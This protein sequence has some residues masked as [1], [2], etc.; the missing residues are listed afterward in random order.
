MLATSL[1]QTLITTTTP[2]FSGVFSQYNRSQFSRTA[3]FAQIGTAIRK[4][5]VWLRKL[6]SMAALIAKHR[7][8]SIAHWEQTFMSEEQDWERLQ[9][10][11]VEL[12]SMM[13]FL[14]IRITTVD[15]INSLCLLLIDRPYRSY[16]KNLLSPFEGTPYSQAA[17]AAFRSNPIFK[18]MNPAWNASGQNQKDVI[19]D[20]ASLFKTRRPTSLTEWE[21]VYL[22]GGR[23][24]VALDAIAEVFRSHTSIPCEEVDEVTGRTFH[25]TR[26]ATTE[27][28]KLAMYIHLFDETFEGFGHEKAALAMLRT[29]QLQAEVY[30]Y[31]IENAIRSGDTSQL[32]LL[33]RAQGLGE[34]ILFGETS[35]RVDRKFAIDLQG[36]LGGKVAIAIQTKGASF[37]PRSSRTENGKHWDGE[38]MARY[39]QEQPNVPVVYMFSNDIHAYQIKFHAAREVAYFPDAHSCMR[40]SKYCE[41]PK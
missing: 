27:E 17:R 14:G 18:A 37:L 1:A 13:E 24:M 28:A 38:K 5:L 8:A 4:D 26:L 19:T 34:D 33:T 36:F 21:Q 35:E 6:D 3:L 12:V 40:T 7:P 15:A 23:S 16:Q 11:A 30:T 22:A 29:W 20:Y 9:T 39:Q 41:L 32:F 31:L 2:F 10:A 25:T